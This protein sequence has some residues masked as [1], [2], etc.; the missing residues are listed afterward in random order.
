MTTASKK[1][2]G[3]IGTSNDAGVLTHRLTEYEGLDCAAGV[4]FT[5]SGE[6]WFVGCVRRREPMASC[7]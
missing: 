2:E 6:H 7:S 3:M 4:E 5:D 1:D